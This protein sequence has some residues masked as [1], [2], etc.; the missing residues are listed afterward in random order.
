MR[1]DGCGEYIFFAVQSLTEPVQQRTVLIYNE[2]AP[3]FYYPKG[4]VQVT[5]LIFVL[6]KKPV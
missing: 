3:D 6:K 5:K 1:E 2:Y 4:Q